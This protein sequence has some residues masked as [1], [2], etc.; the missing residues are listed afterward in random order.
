MKK[1]FMLML[2]TSTTAWGETGKCIVSPQLLAAY[3]AK[4]TCESYKD[5]KPN[6]APDFCGKDDDLVAGKL[7][8]APAVGAAFMV[9]DKIARD[10]VIYKK[11]LLEEAQQSVRAWTAQKILVQMMNT[12]GTPLKSPL[13]GLLDKIKLGKIKVEPAAIEEWMKYVNGKDEEALKRFLT[14]LGPDSSLQKEL[15]ELGNNPKA[16]EQALKVYTET[17]AKD[18]AHPSPLYQ[19]LAVAEAEAVK[20]E[21]TANRFKLL[22]IPVGFLVATGT[23]ASAVMVY[24][25]LKNPTLTTISSTDPVAQAALY[26]QNYDVNGNNPPLTEEQCTQVHVLA[27]RSLGFE[28][29]SMTCDSVSGGPIL[30]AKR[31]GKNYQITG[32]AA[33][34]VQKHNA[35]TGW[36]SVPKDNPEWVAATNAFSLYLQTHMDV[37]KKTDGAS[38]VPA[39][40]QGH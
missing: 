5:I 33:D 10:N 9:S 34:S 26:L 38:Q 16:R 39:G 8:I 20:V 19:K 14:A 37:C 1:I 15:L 11:V 2:I 17:L 23:L 29:I 13:Q 24:G 7:W 32:N 4:V 12:A 27:N 25:T 18:V 35:F 40:I 6:K 22:R 28:D 3:M 21:K 36:S 31:N 30:T